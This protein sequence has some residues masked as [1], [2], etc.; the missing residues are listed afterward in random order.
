MPLAVQLATLWR[1]EVAIGLH[2]PFRT[3]NC[4]SGNSNPSANVPLISNEHSGKDESDRSNN[5]IAHASLHCL[6]RRPSSQPSSTL[7]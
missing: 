7:A 3:S 5:R 4:H 1:L 6:T 2:R